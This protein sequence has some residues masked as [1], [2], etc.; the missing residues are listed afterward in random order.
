MADEQEQATERASAWIDKELIRDAKLVASH[1][2]DTLSEVLERL[3]RPGLA[4]DKAR[5]VADLTKTTAKAG[6]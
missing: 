1:D 2:G 4:K 5:V 6:A 3:L